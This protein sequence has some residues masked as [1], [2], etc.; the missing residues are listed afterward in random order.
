MS[1]AVDQQLAI[2]LDRR[3]HTGRRHARAHRRHQIAR[4]HDDGLA[5]FQIRGH[6]TERNGQAIER[7]NGRDRQRGASQHLL[8]LLALNQAPRQDET[9]VGHAERITHQEFAIVLLAAEPQLLAR[10]TVFERVFPIHRAQQFLN[11]RDRHARRVQAAD[12]R[13]HAGA[14]DRI[15]GNAHLVEHFEH[16]DVGRAPRA[17]ATEHQTDTRSC[18]L[19]GTAS[20]GDIDDAPRTSAMNIANNDAGKRRARH[21]G[22]AFIVEIISQSL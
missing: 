4:V 21:A 7:L 19:G 10:R 14:G 3:K 2:A 6:G 22:W 1:P 5:C 18:L 15:D 11:I 13:A 12:H 16:T 8:Q 20:T 17:A 9:L